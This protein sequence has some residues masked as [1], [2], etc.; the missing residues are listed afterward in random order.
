[1]ILASLFGFTPLKYK[2]EVFECFCNFQSLVESLFDKKILAMQT[3]WGG[4]YQKLNST[5]TQK[6]G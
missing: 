6:L 5:P 2:S 4:E 3:D 1:M